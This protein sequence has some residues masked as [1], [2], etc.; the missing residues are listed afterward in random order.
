MGGMDVDVG[1]GVDSLAGDGVFVGSGTDTAEMGVV[2]VRFGWTGGVSLET[3]VADA[4][5]SGGV[6]T[7]GGNTGVGAGVGIA[8]TAVAPV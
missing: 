5:G 3:G 1:P 2:G 8:G 6:V 4:V 7:E